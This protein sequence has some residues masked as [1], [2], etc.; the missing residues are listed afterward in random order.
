MI[1]NHYAM[2]YFTKKQMKSNGKWYPVATTIG[3]PVTTKEVARRLSALSS[4]ST[5]DVISVLDLLGGVLG[6]F[7]N[8]GRTVK[9]EG[10]G[11]FYY[12]IDAE[13]NG[14]D[15]AD[16][17]SAKQITGTRVRFIPETARGS[18][19]QIVS[20]SLIAED[21]FWELLSEDIPA[22]PVDDTTPGTGGEDDD[23]SGQ[24]TFG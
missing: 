16:E 5:G 8:E 21:V 24:G 7:M 9:L 23:D 10:V 4:L 2:G 18:K 11:T 12:T 19:G 13:G 17:V 1:I 20:R 3:K 6:Q 15:T 22:Q 14:V